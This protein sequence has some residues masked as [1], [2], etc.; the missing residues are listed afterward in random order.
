MSNFYEGIE[1][2]MVVFFYSS[3]LYHQSRVHHQ[4]AHAQTCLVIVKEMNPT[5]DH[6]FLFIL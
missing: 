3:Q 2:S 4:M 5:K 6:L 1:T